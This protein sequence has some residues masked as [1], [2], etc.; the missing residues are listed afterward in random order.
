[1]PGLGTAVFAD[2]RGHG[3]H[4]LHHNGAWRRGALH[5][6]G[7]LLDHAGDA[8]GQC[9][10]QRADGQGAQHA[11]VRANDESTEQIH[12]KAPAATLAWPLPIQ[13]TTER[14]R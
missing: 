3:A 8:T 2:G 10:G 9:A 4:L 1:M 12:S 7:A 13:L 14:L 11:T 6:D 5:H